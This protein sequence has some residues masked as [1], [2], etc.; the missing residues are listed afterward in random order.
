MT[1]EQLVE[2]AWGLANSEKMF[3]WI[4][5]PD[6]VVG[7]AAVVPQ[8]FVSKTKERG[9]LASWCPQEQVLSHPAI[10]G[11]LTHCGWNSTIESIG[12]GVP[13]ICWPFFAEQ[14]T[15]CRYCCR[16]WGIGM[17]IE[18]VER[19]NIEG[20]VRKLMEGEKGKEMKKR[21]MEWKKLAEDAIAL[22]QLNLDKM[23]EQ[24]LLSP[25]DIN[26]CNGTS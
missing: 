7:E 15:N 18:D 20:L 5:R 19:G 3:L 11:F 6:L 1:A 16:E 14:Q 10:G 24:V 17:E 21:A 4:I 25:R 12:Y 2:F 9:L 13:V 23:I 8:E 22:S 26:E